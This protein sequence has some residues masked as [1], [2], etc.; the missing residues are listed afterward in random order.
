MFTK[1]KGGYS[2]EDDENLAFETGNNGNSTT[3]N[4]TVESI[5]VLDN[6]D[7]ENIKQEDS[8]TK[9]AMDII[10]KDLQKD[11]KVDKDD[12]ALI[13]ESISLSGRDHKT[14]VDEK[15]D[16][17]DKLKAPVDNETEG[18]ENQTNNSDTKADKSLKVGVLMF[19]RLV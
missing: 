19:L 17:K 1:C 13:Q 8:N 15:D 10:N 4:K 11:S 6:L 3:A 2:V 14:S 7:S 12:M 18:K 5:K 16:V 9:M